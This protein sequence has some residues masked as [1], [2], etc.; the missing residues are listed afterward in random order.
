MEETAMKALGRG[1]DLAYDFRLRFAKAARLVE[2]DQANVRGV[3]VPCRRPAPVPL[4]CTRLQ[5]GWATR[6]CD[7]FDLKF[8]DVI[9]K[10]C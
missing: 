10:L 2:V 6:S 4:R 9:A 1:F 7:S 3:A 5:S 8:F